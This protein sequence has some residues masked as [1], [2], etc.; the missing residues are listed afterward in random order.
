MSGRDTEYG[1]VNRAVWR[2]GTAR[3]CE[4]GDLSY[5]LG[6]GVSSVG[7]CRR[8]LHVGKKLK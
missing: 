6:R 3:G 2:G 8:G 7:G 5:E 4:K 1:K